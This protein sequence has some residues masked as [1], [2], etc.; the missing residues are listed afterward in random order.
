MDHTQTPWALNNSQSALVERWDAML[1]QGSNWREGSK[2][3]E[4]KIRQAEN[5]KCCG[6]LFSNARVFLSSPLLSC[7][8]IKHTTQEPDLALIAVSSSSRGLS[9]GPR[10]WGWVGLPSTGLPQNWGLWGPRGGGLWCHGCDSCATTGPLTPAITPT[11]RDT[12]AWSS[13]MSRSHL[14]WAPWFRSSPE[15][16]G[17]FDTPAITS[18]PSEAHGR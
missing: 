18:R 17:K 10:K 7:Q 4:T 9:C 6:T 12:T 11:L 1:Y 3:G 13:A 14:Q 16:L 15:E 2:E 5:F 8:G